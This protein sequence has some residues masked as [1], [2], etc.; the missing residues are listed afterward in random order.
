M[1]SFNQETIMEQNQKSSSRKK[2]LVWGAAALSSFTVFG[3]F[4]GSKKEEKKETLKMLTQ[5][6]K[7]VEI[8]ADKIYGSRREKVTD[9]QLKNWINK[10]KS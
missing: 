5:D 7:L 1:L 8:D 10:K 3:L 6:G 4:S 2:F 9:E